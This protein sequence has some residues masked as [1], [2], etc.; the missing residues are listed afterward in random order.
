MNNTVYALLHIPTAEYVTVDYKT[1]LCED[2]PAA[3]KLLSIMVCD[4]TYYWGHPRTDFRIGKISLKEYE[5]PPDSL[6]FDIVAIP[7]N[8][9]NE[10][11][12]NHILSIGFY[13]CSKTIASII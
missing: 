9:L 3:N 2:I 8:V 11:S 12:Y 7:K 6:E 10:E 5:I 1:A 4:T 13:Y